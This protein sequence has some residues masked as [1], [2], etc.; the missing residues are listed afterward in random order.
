FLY[1]ADRRV[2][3]FGYRRADR[4]GEV[5]EATQWLQAA[6][7]RW[8]LLPEERL[9]PCFDPRRAVALGQAHRELWFLVRADMALPCGGE[10][11]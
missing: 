9:T 6:P 3:T 7:G 1:Q 11:P 10:S 2:T 4:L 5:M 8:V